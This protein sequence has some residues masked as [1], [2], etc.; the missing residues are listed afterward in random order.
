MIAFIGSV[1]SPY[2]AHRRARAAAGG[3]GAGSVD[4]TD[5]CAVNVALYSPGAARWTMTERGRGSVDAASGHLAIGPSA[6]RWTGDALCIDVDEVA[7]PLPARVRG[8]I[9]VHPYALFDEDHALDP[10]GRHHWRPIAPAALVE[11]EMSRPDL[12]WSGIGYL[13]SNRGAAP[14][15]R[16]F[17]R[18]DWCRA[19]L[20]RHRTGVYYDVVPRDGAPRSLAVGFDADG[21]IEPLAPLPAIALAPTRWRIPRRARA[22]RP[23]AVRVVRTREDAPFYARSV[24]SSTWQQSPV[25]VVHESLSLDRF[26]SPWVRMLLPFRMPRRR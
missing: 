23:E 5:H 15:E 21:S 12:C 2:C 6:V 20:P 3:A 10:A 18:W 8:R 11:V 26:A 22:D 1:F 16:D 4:P 25:T 19:A 14:L 7:A 13:D 24:L 17:R 9:R